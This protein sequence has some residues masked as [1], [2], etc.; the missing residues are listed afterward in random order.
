M[1]FKRYGNVADD[2]Q[3]IVFIFIF[4]DFIFGSTISQWLPF[5]Q[6]AQ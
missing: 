4:I 6:D 2:N 5:Y 3:N 1:Y